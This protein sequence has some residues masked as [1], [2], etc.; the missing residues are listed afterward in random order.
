MIRPAGFRKNEQT[1]EDNLYQKSLAEF[2]D[3]EINALAQREFDQM[4]CLLRSHGVNVL[5]I[6]D[7]PSTDTPDALFPNNWISF[8]EPGSIITYPMLTENRRKER[9]PDII[10]IVRKKYLVDSELDFSPEELDGKILE[11]TGSMVLDRENRI[12]YISLSERSNK[13]LAQDFCKRM[14][15]KPIFFNSFQNI[16]GYK[17]PIYHTNVMM[18]V[19]SDLALIC[20]DVIESEKERNEVID[21]LLSSGKSIIYLTEEQ[22]NNFAGNALEVRGKDDKKIIFMSTSGIQSLDP[23]QLEEIAYKIPILHTPLNTIETC[24]GGSAR[25]MMAEVFLELKNS[26]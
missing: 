15:Y 10:D 16:N 18:S 2:S 9:R 8:H 13:I 24:G 20:T 11:G 4:V 25:C 6:N 23:Q 12:A 21:S 3:E 19:G 14:D 22:I 17:Y 1:S 7:D 26:K 5:V